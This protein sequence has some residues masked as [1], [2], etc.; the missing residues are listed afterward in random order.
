VHTDQ[1]TP[2]ECADQILQQL[3]QL[4]YIPVTETA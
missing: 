1:N 3:E 4:G 2:E